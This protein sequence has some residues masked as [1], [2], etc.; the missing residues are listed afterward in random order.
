[1]SNRKESATNI[2]DVD[3]YGNGP[4]HYVFLRSELGYPR[5]FVT[6]ALE[7]LIQAGAGFNQRNINGETPSDYAHSYGWINEWYMAL[8]ESGMDLNEVEILR[9]H[10]F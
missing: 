4:L 1:M 9:G 5:L 7:M 10:Q 3:P 2:D 8:E 6:R